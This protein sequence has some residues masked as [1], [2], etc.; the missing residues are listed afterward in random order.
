LYNILAP[1]RAY[2]EKGYTNI[3]DSFTSTLL[4]SDHKQDNHIW[5]ALKS[6][7]F[8]KQTTTWFPW[9]HQNSFTG[10][11]LSL[12]NGQPAANQNRVFTQTMV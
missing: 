9:L 1:P 3:N 2:G 11:P 5:C 4:A 8:Y 7:N 12:F 6:K 10:C